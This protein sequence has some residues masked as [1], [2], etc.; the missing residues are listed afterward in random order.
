MKREKKDDSS[1]QSSVVVQPK[2]T[3][4]KAKMSAVKQMKKEDSELSSQLDNG[5]YLRTPVGGKE[6]DVFKKE[7]SNPF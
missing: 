1:S 3:M 5:L 4:S 2:A 7:D 6:T